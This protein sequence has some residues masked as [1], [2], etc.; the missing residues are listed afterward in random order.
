MFKYL[1]AHPQLYLPKKEFHHFGQDLRPAAYTGHKWD[2]AAYMALFEGATTEKRLG[3]A[4]VWYLYSKEAAREIKA[5]NPEADII[6]MLRNPVEMMYSLYNLFLWVRDLTPNGVIDAESGRV[7]SFD[8]ALQ[9]QEQRKV[10]FLSSV[11]HEAL[12]G[13]RVLRLFHTQVA[14]YADQVKRYLDIYDP[15]HLH[16]ILYDDL[17][18]DAAATY[19]DTLQFLGVDP[20]YE[21]DF[22]VINSSRHIRNMSL[23]RLLNTH[24]SMQWVRKVGRVVVPTAWRKRVFALVQGTNVQHKPRPPMNPETRRWLQDL[25]RPDVE[26]LSTL[27]DRDLVARWKI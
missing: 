1:Q 4:S 23:H 21:A 24:T 18:A 20:S 2:R 15:A 17:K 11:D 19:R 16:C 7:L 14:Q 25:F 27:L 3:E 9:T 5:F 6:I 10:A 26:R 8:E 13:K 12:A 22:R